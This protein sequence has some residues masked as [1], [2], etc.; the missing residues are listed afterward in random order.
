M[1]SRRLCPVLLLSLGACLAPPL[2]N[3]GDGGPVDAAVAGACAEVTPPAACAEADG[4]IHPV[5]AKDV[6]PAL[7]G[8]WL[9]CHGDSI[10][11]VYAN[12]KVGPANNVGLEIFGDGTWHFLI[13]GE[14]GAIVP[15]VGFTSGGNWKIF[16]YPPNVPAGFQVNFNYAEG[17]GLFPAHVSFTDGPR[18]MALELE[19]HTSFYLLSPPPAGCGAHG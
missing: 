14:G 17:N 11:A 15:R 5:T 7:P 8:R 19:G 12:F 2:P 6:A 18:K 4:P 13:A 9:F 3:S 1:I 10:G 16:D